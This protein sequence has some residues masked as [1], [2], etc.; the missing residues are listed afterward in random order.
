MASPSSST[1][2]ASSKRSCEIPL[3]TT[4]FCVVVSGNCHRKLRARPRRCGQKRCCC[5]RESLDGN[6]SAAFPDGV[7]LFD[8]GLRAFPEVLGL[9]EFDHRF[10]R[11]TEAG[12]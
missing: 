12:L 3:R 4:Q 10:A 6:W 5:W 9:R 7:A 8:E 1:T 11:E 2:T